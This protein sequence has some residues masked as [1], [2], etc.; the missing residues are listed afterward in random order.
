MS[1]GKGVL[2]RICCMCIL[3]LCKQASFTSKVIRPK[4]KKKNDIMILLITIS[5]YPTQVPV[6]KWKMKISSCNLTT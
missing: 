4:K 1:K 6:Y 5:Q 2:K 3:H